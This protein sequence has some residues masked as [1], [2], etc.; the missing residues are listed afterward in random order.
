M[1][2]AWRN[3]TVKYAG[4]SSRKIVGMPPIRRRIRKPMRAPCLVRIFFLKK[5]QSITILVH[6]NCNLIEHLDPIEKK[7]LRREGLR[8]NKSSEKVGSGKAYKPERGLVL[9]PAKA[10]E[11]D[12][13]MIGWGW[14]GRL[15]CYRG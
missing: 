10:N 12:S 6:A 5:E 4:S 14:L 7:G 13:E 1:S 15:F 9:N 11:F 3:S 8:V 2:P